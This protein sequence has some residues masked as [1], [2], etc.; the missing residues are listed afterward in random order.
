[1]PTHREL[2]DDDKLFTNEE[3]EAFVALPAIK[4]T[5][6]TIYH[7][8]TGFVQKP[9]TLTTG[10]ATV[11]VSATF[12]AALSAAGTA[13]LVA[14][15]AA[16]LIRHAT[17]TDEEKKKRE[18]GKQCVITLLSFVDNLIDNEEEMLEYTGQ[19]ALQTD[20]TERRVTREFR[21]RA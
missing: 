21:S 18:K 7:V 14:Y 20:P 13:L 9:V 15:L 12:A 6:S 8:R 3:I 2:D 1:M 4:I 5:E 10:T 16:M 19:R 11:G 17:K